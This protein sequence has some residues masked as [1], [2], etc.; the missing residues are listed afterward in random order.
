[1]QDILF[2]LPFILGAVAVLQGALNRVVA[3]SWGLTPTIVLN[4]FVIITMGFLFYISVKFY[5]Q[6]FPDN[7][8]DKAGFTSF[9]WYYLLPGLCGLA[10]VAGIPFAIGQ[11]GAANVFIGIVCAQM[12]TSLIWDQLKEGIALS[13][14]R[15]LGA[16]LTIVGVFV[17]RIKS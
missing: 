3:Q 13:W 15:L 6:F 2:I 10:L 12:I 16:I 14:P 11:I 7:F 5:P 4:N 8:R 9:S 17:S 1:M